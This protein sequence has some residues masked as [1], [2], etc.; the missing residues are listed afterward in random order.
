[1]RTLSKNRHVVQ[2]EATVVAERRDG[3][4]P[5][6]K[7]P[8]A[9]LEA[10][11]KKEQLLPPGADEINASFSERLD[12]PSL[13]EE[14]LIAPLAYDYWRQ[15]GCPEGCPEDD[16]FRAEQEIRSRTSIPANGSR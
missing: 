6:T 1:M 11:E 14:D 9:S 15:R 16:W 13:T 5:E 2:N 12:K 8:L 10:F 7:E 3:M 4:A